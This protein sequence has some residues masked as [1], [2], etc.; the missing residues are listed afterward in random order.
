MTAVAQNIKRMVKVLGAKS[1]PK[2]GV[3]AIRVGK[4]TEIH[5]LRGMRPPQS[6]T[7]IAVSSLSRRPSK[8]SALTERTG[9]PRRDRVYQQPLTA[10]GLYP[11]PSDRPVVNYRRPL[12]LSSR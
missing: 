12:L 9:V 7:R 10:R 4:N 1:P 6:P 2:A 3:L 8:L 11:P 5:D